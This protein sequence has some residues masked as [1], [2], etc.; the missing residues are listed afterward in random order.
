ML[1]LIGRILL[2]LRGGSLKLLLF[3]SIL[4]LVLAATSPLGT[5]VWWLS[6]EA[7]ISLNRHKP[8]SGQR[9]LLP[10]PAAP[11]SKPSE[12]GCYIVFLPGVGDFSADQLT[13]GEAIFFQRLAQ[14]HPECITVQGIFPYSA[15]NENLGGRRLLAPLW[16]FAERAE[17]WWGFANVLIK[18]RNLSRFAI[19]ADPRY[20]VVYNQGIAAAIAERMDAVQPIPASS[21]RPLKIILLGTSG[22]VQVALGAVPYLGEWLKAKIT[23]VSI[24][25]V[26]SGASGFGVA[27]H[28]YHLYGRQDW[29][30]DL[31]VA[32]FPSRRPWAVSSPFNQTR[33]QGGY[34]VQVSGPH[35]HDG[36]Q[37][38][39][40]EARAATT[41]GTY[42]DL[43]LQRV[44]QL[45]I[46]SH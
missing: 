20:G 8:K 26:F 12:P 2:G 14:A 37:G 4:L 9:G 45:P 16:R 5:L 24:G 29:V 44:N 28:V 6:Q 15:A 31:G 13:G 3:A 17:G 42:V 27:E 39:F 33:Q 23:V 22:G 21:P 43:T 19:S 34:T 40:G 7:E 32:V 11:A 35:A 1:Q 36:P 46:W 18:I 25:G 41:G 30:D 10:G 38:Y